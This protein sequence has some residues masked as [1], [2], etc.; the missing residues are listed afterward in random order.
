MDYQ[1][2][3]VRCVNCPTIAVAEVDG[4]ALCEGCLLSLVLSSQ[5]PLPVDSIRSIR[6]AAR[7]I[8]RQAS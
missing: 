7:P 5:E 2:R 8:E 1:P 6:S 4:A 3:R